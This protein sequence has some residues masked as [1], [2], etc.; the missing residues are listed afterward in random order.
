MNIR[1]FVDDDAPALAALIS[2]DEERLYGRPGRLTGPDIMMFVPYNKEAWVWEEDGGIVA[3]A[4]FGIHGEAAN[5]RGFVAKKG[6][7][8]GTE[9]L[10]RGEAFART[11][12]VNKLL[13]GAAEPDAEA[14]A[15]FE[16]RGFREARRFYEM[17]IELTEEPTVPDLPDG[18]VVDELHDDEYEAF[19]EALNEAFAEHWEW[20]PKPYEEWLERR[21]GQHKDEQGP[22]WFVVRDGD[23]LAAVTRNDLS[24]A[25]GGYV[26]AIGVRPAW[27]GKGLAKALLQRTFAEF[28]RRD[29]TRVTLDVDTENA[30]GAV[31]LYERVGMHVDTCGVAFEKALE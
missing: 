13:T 12:G 18:L 24:L 19:Y 26:G 29:T 31:A 17:A 14:R 9:I 11:E 21:Q 16:S 25:G 6:C 15:L 1:P 27:R 30:T 7:G 4:L 23:E 8:L 10:E 3:G 2:A 28:W 20:H 22:I 5:I